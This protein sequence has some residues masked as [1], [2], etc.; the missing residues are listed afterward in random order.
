LKEKLQNF[1]ILKYNKSDIKKAN[2][3]CKT[4]DRQTSS[5][6]MIVEFNILHVSDCKDN[7]NTY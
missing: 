6:F 3:E 5:N 4:H 1:N 7:M 2:N